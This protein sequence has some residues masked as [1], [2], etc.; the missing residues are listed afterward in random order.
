MADDYFFQYVDL[1][2]HLGGLQRFENARGFFYFKKNTSRDA[3]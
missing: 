3:F 1:F 2:S